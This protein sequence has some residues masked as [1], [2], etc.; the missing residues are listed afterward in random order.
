MAWQ[1]PSCVPHAMQSVRSATYLRASLPQRSAAPTYFGPR[2]SL[3]AHSQRRGKFRSYA[4]DVEADSFEAAPAIDFEQ[5]RTLPARVVPMS[6]AYFTGTPKFFDCLLRL[7]KALEDHRHLPTVSSS[8][9]PRVAWLKQ[10]QFQEHI[11]E[12]IPTKKF[13]G[14]VQLLQQLNRIDYKV[15]PESVRLMLKEYTRPG[16]PYGNKS[17]QPTVDELGRA[18]GKGKRKSSSAVVHLVEGEGEVLV[19]GKNLVEAFPRVHDRESV[20]WALR[21]TARLDKYNVW[22]TVSGGGTTG[23]AEA[24]ALALGRALM[25]HEPALKPLLRKAGVI[26]VDARRVERKKPGHVKARKMPTWVKR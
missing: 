14:V 21:S 12:A 11:G 24:I 10:P 5:I 6:P 19:N 1:T 3:S 7:E 15:M 17:V 2:L 20:T 23:Q 4:T 26:T 25:I 22:A 16:N 18:R 9:A 13:K 8:D